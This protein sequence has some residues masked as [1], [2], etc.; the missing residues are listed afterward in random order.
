MAEST[1]SP[2]S[3][4][5]DDFH[6][7]WNIVPTPFDDDGNVDLESVATLVD[8]VIGTGVTGITVLGIAGEAAKLTDAERLSVIRRTITQSGGRVPICVGVNAGSTHATLA[9]AA[10]A[11][12]E[13][14]HSILLSPT[15]GTRADEGDILNHYL[16]VAAAISIP[17]VIQDHPKFSGV[18]MSVDLLC[19]LSQASPSLGTIKLEAAPTSLKIRRLRERSSEI[20]ILGGLTGVMLLE[21]LQAGADGTMTGFG[22][23]EILAA[24]VRTFR[25][26]DA[27]AAAALFY[28]YLPIIRYEY[29]DPISLSI[30]KLIYWQRGA[31]RSPHVRAPRAFLDPSVITELADLERRLSLPRAAFSPQP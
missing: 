4:R 21:E 15:P 28:R 9:Y 31:M 5:S 11:A 18:P 13:G 24:V 20:R 6:G 22:Y 12:A 1:A 19:R 25:S 10:E 29:Q 26:G 14:A 17:I 3:Q 23:P 8:F 16:S 7:V 27:E 30:R 2:A